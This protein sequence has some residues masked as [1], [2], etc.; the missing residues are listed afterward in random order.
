MVSGWSRSPITQWWSVW[1]SQVGFVKG[2]VKIIG[3]W[4][5]SCNKRIMVRTSSDSDRFNVSM[6]KCGS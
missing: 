3:L 2:T 6:E 5:I 1:G 4:K